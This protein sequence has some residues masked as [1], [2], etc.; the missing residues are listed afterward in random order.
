MVENKKYCLMS[1]TEMVEFADAMAKAHC[2]STDYLAAIVT[3]KGSVF[4]IVEEGRDRFLKVIFLSLVYA[5]ISESLYYGPYLD[6]A[7]SRLGG[8]CKS[9]HL[10]YSEVQRV[11]QYREQIL[12][13]LK[14]SDSSL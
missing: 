4:R 1:Q 7:V 10:N 14:Q 13:F 9:L 8:A 5:D 3:E 2:D 11:S 6:Q 12:D